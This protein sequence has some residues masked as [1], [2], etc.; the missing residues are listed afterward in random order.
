M[1]NYDEDMGFGDFARDGSDEITHRFEIDA[2]QLEGDSERNHTVPHPNEYNEI[3]FAV[4][5][6]ENIETGNISYE[7]IY[8]PFEG[9]EDWADTLEQD[10]GDEGSLGG[11]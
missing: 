10:Y 1:A 8:G 11:E 5:K 3:D 4:F 6:V 7:T 2:Y 9:W